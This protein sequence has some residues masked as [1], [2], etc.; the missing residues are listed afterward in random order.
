MPGWASPCRSNCGT[1]PTRRVLRARSWTNGAIATS[2]PTSRHSAIFRSICRTTPLRP[3][4]PNLSSARRQARDFIYFYIGA[5]AGGGI[6]LNGRLYRRSDRQCR[7][8]GFN[9][10]ARARRQADAADRRRLDRHAGKGA[11]CARRRGFASV[12]FAART[13]ATSAP[14]STD[15]IA[16]ASQALAYAIVAASSVIDFEAAVIDGWMPLT[17]RRRLVDAVVEAIGRIDV[18]GLQAPRRARRH[19]R[20]PC[21]GAGRRQPAAFRALPDRLDHDFQERLSHADRHSGA[22]RSGAAGDFARHGPWRRD[23]ACRR[24]LSGRRNRRSG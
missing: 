12:D 4:A 10:G 14:S 9:A 20:H 13:G 23:R 19:G 7:R 22:A 18:E 2:A 21:A 24:Q 1:G 16:T 3:A 11:Q 17:V 8:A 5:F 15:W 6:V